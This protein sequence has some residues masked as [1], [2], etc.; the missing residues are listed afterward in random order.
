MVWV[1]TLVALVIGV[2]QALDYDDTLKA[3]IVCVIAWVVMLVVMMMVAVLGVG[4]AMVVRAIARVTL[5]PRADRRPRVV[6]IGGG[7]GGLSAAKAL[8][9]APVDVLL[10]DRRNHHVFQPLLYQV[11]TAGLSPGDIASPI[12]WILRKQKNV[13]VWLAEAVGDRRRAPRARPR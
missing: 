12:R 8:N 7:F 2:R 5:R 3:V 9:G 4:A 11:A 6:I 13:R 10:V 1:W